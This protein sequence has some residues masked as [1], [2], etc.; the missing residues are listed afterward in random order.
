[1]LLLIQYVD[2]EVIHQKYFF[3]IYMGSCCY[4]ETKYLVT[5][6]RNN[7]YQAFT[8]KISMSYTFFIQLVIFGVTN[9]LLF[10]PRNKMFKLKSQHLFQ[11]S[12]A[13]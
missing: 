5:V 11:S 9:A 2:H 6:I 8:A 10:F 3:I 13:N 7:E 12:S 4:Y 1:M